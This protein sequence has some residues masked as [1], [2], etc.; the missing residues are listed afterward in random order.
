MLEAPLSQVT[1]PKTYRAIPSRFPPIDAFERV[2]NAEEFD[3]LFALESMTNPRLRDQVGDI[4]LVPNEERVFGPGAN[5]VMAAFTHVSDKKPSR[6]SNGSYGIYYAAKEQVTA[7]RETAHHLGR[8]FSDTA[9]GPGETS[10]LRMLVGRVDA[11]FRDIRVGFDFL[12]H[13]NDYAVPQAFGRELRDASENGVVY[14]SVRHPGGECLAAFKPK[15]VSIPTQGTHYEYHWNGEE[16]DK[17]WR[18]GRDDE[19]NAIWDD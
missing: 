1:W 14:R 19:W 13:P 18:V 8:T 4:T 10:Q 17:Y 15:A 9:A 16:F 3:D 11:W 5:W 7:I 2:S 12:H 6:F